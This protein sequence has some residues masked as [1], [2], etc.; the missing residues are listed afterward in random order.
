MTGVF[1]VCDQDHSQTNCKSIGFRYL[2]SVA[3]LNTLQVNSRGP[4]L[5][6]VKGIRVAGAIC[7][8]LLWAVA[9]VLSCLLPCLASVTVKQDCS[10]HMAMEC[11]ARTI[12][13]GRDCCRMSS[14]PEL[15]AVGAQISPPQKRVLPAGLVVFQTSLPGMLTDRPASLF[16]ESPPDEASPPSFPVLRI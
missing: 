4:K 1:S 7:T 10:H 2:V 9:P 3:K 14:R 12:T 11:P 8:V 6:Q 5:V 15:A 13:T 16:F